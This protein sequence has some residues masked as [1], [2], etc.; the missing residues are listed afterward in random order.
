MNEVSDTVQLPVLNNS[1]GMKLKWH[2]NTVV[3][4]DFNG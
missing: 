2:N 3:P 1:M 4:F